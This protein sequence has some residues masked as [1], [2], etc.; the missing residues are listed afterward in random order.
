MTSDPG[1]A[2]VK[3]GLNKRS[4]SEDLT[5][6]RGE[7]ETYLKK[8]TFRWEWRGSESG[9]V[10]EYKPAYMT[11]KSATITSFVLR[12]TISLYCFD[13]SLTHFTDQPYSFRVIQRIQ[14]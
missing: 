14:D 12:K 9:L 11:Q 6:Q 7:T 8:I 13:K 4:L 2:R 1:L 3:T 10:L 5:Y